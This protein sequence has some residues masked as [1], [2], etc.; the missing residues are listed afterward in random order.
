[1]TLVEL[2][3]EYRS[4]IEWMQKNIGE[5]ESDLS[6]SSEIEKEYYSMRLKRMNDMLNESEKLLDSITKMFEAG[7][8]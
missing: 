8:T 5:L 1:M 6:E 4:N 3:E 2:S 7:E